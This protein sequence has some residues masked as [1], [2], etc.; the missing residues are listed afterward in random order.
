VVV[1]VLVVGHALQKVLYA[2][3]LMPLVKLQGT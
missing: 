1:V 2:T 3:R